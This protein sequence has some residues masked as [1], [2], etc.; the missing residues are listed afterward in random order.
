MKCL[1]NEPRIARLV[2]YL[3]LTTK[4]YFSANIYICG[5][6]F[7][8]QGASL[9]DYSIG[10]QSRPSIPSLF[11]S[12]ECYSLDLHTTINRSLSRRTECKHVVYI[13]PVRER[14][15]DLSSLHGY[16]TVSKRRF[17][18]P[19]LCRYLPTPFYSKNFLCAMSTVSLEPSALAAGAW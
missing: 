16:P 8:W 6:K 2:Q 11:G 13:P 1:S 7:L 15:L 4:L 3:P 10:C 5:N 14:C 17:S 18:A 12:V 9:I 19:G